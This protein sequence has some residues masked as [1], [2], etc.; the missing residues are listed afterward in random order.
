[1]RI[2]WLALGLIAACAHGPKPNEAV[3]THGRT[4]N[5]RAPV[6]AATYEGNGLV[7]IAFGAP[8]KIVVSIPTCYAHAQSKIGDHDKIQIELADG[9]VGATD[10]ELDIDDCTTKHVVATLRATFPDGQHVE[11]RF[12]TDLK[13]QP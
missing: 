1:V 10:G 11:A 2:H 8:A 13:G 9:H 3:S 4:T 5:W 12:D 6:A 7:K